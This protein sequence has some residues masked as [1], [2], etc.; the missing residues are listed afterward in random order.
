MDY[1][2]SFAVVD[3]GLLLLFCSLFIVPS[4]HL[5]DVRENIVNYNRVSTNQ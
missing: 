2:L 1:S 4:R 3:L 5:H